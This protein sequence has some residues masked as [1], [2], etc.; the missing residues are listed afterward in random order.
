MNYHDTPAGRGLDA[1][2]ACDV[3]KGCGW[4]L[5]KDENGIIHNDQD[6]DE[7]EGR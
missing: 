1:I 6:T 4:P 5:W 2:V 3:N 7:G